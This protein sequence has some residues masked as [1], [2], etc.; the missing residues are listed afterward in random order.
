MTGPPAGAGLRILAFPKRG[1]DAYTGQLARHLEARGAI[2]DPFTFRRALLGRY[3]VV[4]L[5]WPESHLRA[6]RW[7]RALAKHARLF[8]LCVLLRLRRTRIC[9]TLHNLR[10]HEHDH[11]LSERLFPLWF[12]RLCTHVIALSPTGLEQARARFPVLGRK[13]AAIVPLGHFRDAYPPGPPRAECRARLGLP[14]EG[15][16]FLFLGTIRRYKNVPRL[17]DAFRDLTDRDVQLVVAGRPLFGVRPDAILARAA[18]DPRIHC[19]LRFLADPEVPV[20]LGAADLVVLPFED[21]LNSG[22]VLLALSLDRRVL[23]PRL[24]ALPD[25]EQL[26]GARWLRLYAG[27]LTAGI[28]A[29]ARRAV[30]GTRPDERADLSPFDWK[31]I[32]DATLAFYRASGARFAGSPGSPMPPTA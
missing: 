26:V 13:A 32:A 15:F 17:V 28:L 18:G 4:H 29:E 20:F 5:H 6:R 16:T 24:G 27:P 8:A 10:P 9:W 31:G 2:V 23:A 7:W 12:P 3:D 1:A 30:T 21:V 14:A 22:S 25:L 19:H 11:W